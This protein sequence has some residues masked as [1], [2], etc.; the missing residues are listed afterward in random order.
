MDITLV[1]HLGSTSSATDASRASMA[2]GAQPVAKPP[3]VDVGRVLVE[4]AVA[5]STV[6]IADAV[7]AIQEAELPTVMVVRSELNVDDEIGRASC[8]A[9]VCQYVY[10]SVVAVSLKK[11]INIE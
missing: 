11:K 6:E 9:R 1:S 8:R 5:V 7:P 2:K 10:I 3:A 4:K